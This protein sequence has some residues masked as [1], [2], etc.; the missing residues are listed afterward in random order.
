MVTSRG[1]MSS[2]K[3][4]DQSVKLEK[5]WSHTF[6]ATVSLTQPDTWYRKVKEIVEKQQIGP[7]WMSETKVSYFVINL[8]K[9]TYFHYIQNQNGI[10]IFFIF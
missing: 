6:T 3:L 1:R 10:W 5:L 9:K 8:H 4:F 7:L 2:K